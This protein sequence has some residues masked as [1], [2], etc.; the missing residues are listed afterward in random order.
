MKTIKR[1]A[2]AALVVVIL[3][4]KAAD[5]SFGQTNLNFNGA[6]ATV[7]GAILLSWNST[8]NEVYEID[9][10]D[11]LNTNVDGTTVWNPLYRDYP[12]HGSQ[13]FIADAGNYDYTPVISHPS[14]SPMRFYR[15]MLV[16]GN[17]SSS[18]PSV[19]IMS[20]TNGASLSGDVTIKVVGTS[21]EIL[22]EVKLYIDGEEQWSS[23]GT[24]NSAGTNLF[25]INTCEWPNGPHTLFATAKSQSG[26]E[27]VANGGTI[28]YGR[29]VSPYVNV[30]F[31]NL[32]SRFDFSQP[33]FEPALGQ[34]QK[35]TAQFTA[36]VNWTLEI[37]NVNSNDV[38]QVTGSGS[39]ME[40]DWDGTGTGSTNI[41]DGVYSYLLTVATNGMPLVLGGG[42]G[43]G[44]SGPPSP[45]FASSS[46][47]GT[48]SSLE[49]LA[50]PSDG[51][52]STVPLAIYPPGFDT[53]G[54]T[55]FQGSLVDYLPRPE[56]P[57]AA[58][59][60]AMA[61]GTEDSPA[62]SGPSQSTRGPKRKPRV[63]VKGE[64]GTFGICYKTYGTNGFSSPHPL[65][66]WPF[67][68]QTRVAIDGQSPTALTEDYRVQNFKKMADDFT[69]V[70]T[71]AAWKSKFV[72]DDSQW[73]AT[74]IQ[75][76]SLGGNSIFNTC[77]FGILMTHGSYANNNNQGN[78]SDSIKY[79]YCWLG[80]NNYVK[81]SNM[82]FGS[83]GTNGLR[84]MTIFA[85]NILKPE[86]QASMSDI[87]P[88]NDNLHLLL[89]F[90]TTGYASYNLGKY[91]AN[92]L[93]NSNYTIISALAN[94][95][96]DSYYENS[97][98]ITNIVRF[99][100]V[101]WASCMNDSLSLYNDPDLNSVDYIERTVFIPQ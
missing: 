95:C 80:G 87:L 48:D 96:T 47:L 28:T 42:G 97:T 25:V 26:F 82:D 76:V 33:Y 53:N 61:S 74:D 19:F 18:N 43:I 35:I 86:N 84:W 71:K 101:G 46:S 30:T 22:S 44:G 5:P 54:M 55:I 65:T 1:V 2:S 88:V 10:A 79:T 90:S 37:Q 66:G 68:L 49:W 92:Y 75:K 51:S 56:V 11:A 39:S 4:I 63:G 98:G 67:P 58:L 36:N 59:S 34:T 20:T 7:E 31:D 32:I 6:K 50:V 41:P 17:D 8:S 45:S 52:G 9:Y 83:S 72:K 64:I 3:L 100:A 69:Q 62:F 16:Q 60:V 40:F 89:G 27:G 21:S 85:C 12:S 38:R 57:L 93:V 23:I 15:V 73:G 77:N 29:S 94:A 91:Y 24:T 14:L 78:S 70:M 13:T 81:L 99:R